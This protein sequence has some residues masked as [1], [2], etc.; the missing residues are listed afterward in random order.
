MEP[1]DLNYPSS[2]DRRLEQML[3][4]PMVPLAD[5]GFSARV[6]AG[7]P[8]KK[9]AA[10][11]ILRWGLC[12][13]GATLGAAL[14]VKKGLAPNAWDQT[15]AQLN[16]ALANVSVLLTDPRVFTAFLITGVSLLFALKPHVFAA[17][18]LS[19]KKP[20]ASDRL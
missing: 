11:S 13:T 19:T 8:E 20:T 5:D 7:L 18:I 6:L 1:A 14:A 15:G 17:L 9:S 3:G 10:P 12:L 2:P 16:E 4:Q